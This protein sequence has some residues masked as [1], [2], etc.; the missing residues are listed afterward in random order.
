VRRV[1]QRVAGLDAEERL[2]GAGI[3]VAEVVDVAGRDR[4]QP[5]RRRE[6]RELGNEPLLD[7]EVTPVLSDEE[8]AAAATRARNNR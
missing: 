3:L 2:V 8:A 7:L 5:G 4:R 1:L 6:L